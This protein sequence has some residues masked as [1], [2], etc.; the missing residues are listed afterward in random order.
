MKLTRTAAAEPAEDD[1][2]AVAAKAPLRGRR[3]TR[4]VW[5]FVSALVGVLALAI[6]VPLAIVLPRRARN[7]APKSSVIV[8]LYVYPALGAW[9]PLHE[10]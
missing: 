4:R 3:P 5:L 7:M 8:P 2:V 6:I 1:G 10:A 9:D